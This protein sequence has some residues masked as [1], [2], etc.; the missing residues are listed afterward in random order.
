MRYIECG[1]GIERAK[2]R[3]SVL[4]DRESWRLIRLYAQREGM[5]PRGI[6]SSH[7]TLAAEQIVAD[8]QEDLDPVSGER[9]VNQ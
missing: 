7:A 9:I 6:L 1:D 4:L 3:I 5:D 2:I 8:L